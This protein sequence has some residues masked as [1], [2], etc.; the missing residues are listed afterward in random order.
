MTLLPGKLPPALLQ[1]LLRFRGAPDPR[2]VLG[3]AFGEDAAVIDLVK[4]IWS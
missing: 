2:V 4:K 3:P 1:R